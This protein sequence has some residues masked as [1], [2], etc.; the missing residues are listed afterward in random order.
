[1]RNPNRLRDPRSL[2]ALPLALAIGGVTLAAI[3]GC[4]PGPCES[5]RATSRVM[6]APDAPAADRSKWPGIRL[7]IREQ[8]A[9]PNVMAI[10]F[11]YHTPDMPPKTWKD[12]LPVDPGFVARA[13]NAAILEVG[14]GDVEFSVRVV[15]AAGS[16]ACQKPNVQ[17]GDN[18]NQGDHGQ[19]IT[20][21]VEDLLP[22]GGMR[23]A[24]PTP[25]I[26]SS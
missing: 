15:A 16:T 24:W 20:H 6:N 2:V 1:M 17:F 14:P 3:T 5:P 21:P 11:G 19:V 8:L 13:S 9:G 18:G 4:S 10:Y 12:S 23:P 25:A 26:I 7:K 22:L